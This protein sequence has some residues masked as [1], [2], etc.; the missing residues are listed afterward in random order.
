MVNRIFNIYKDVLN[1]NIY[2]ISDFFGINNILKISEINTGHINKTYLVDCRA[3]KY[4]LQ[5]L[6]RNVFKNPDTVMNNI[7]R[8]EKAFSE[9]D[10]KTIAVPHYLTADGKS[11]VEVGGEVWRL[12]EYTEQSYVSENQAYMTGYAFGRYIN[13]INN[14]SLN[15]T[16]EDFHNFNRYYNK[17]PSDMKETFS[18]L[19]EQFEIFADVPKRNVHN[20]AKTD[21]I[22]FGNK[23]TV[24]DLDTSMNG[25]VAIDYGDM[26]RSSRIEDISEITKGF[27]D[28]LDGILTREEINSLYYGILYVISE[29]AVRYI[30][31]SVSEKRYFITKTPLQCRKRAYDLLEQLDFF[32]NNSDIKNIILKAF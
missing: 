2:E 26:I 12:Y 14:I 11:F 17:L 29:L 24:I 27:A 4:I 3:G 22:I 15:D 10:E 32:R 5:S 6:N 21:N 18:G 13:T 9:S 19:R 30:I 20:D 25:F 16:I 28:G 31:D 7:E 8:I 23:I 1:I